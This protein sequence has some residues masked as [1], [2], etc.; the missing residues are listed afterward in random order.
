M[1]KFPKPKDLEK[2]QKKKNQYSSLKRTAI[3]PKK[4]RSKGEKIF[5]AGDHFCMKCFADRGVKN[6][7]LI[8]HGHYTGIRQN[9]FGKGRGIKVSDILKCPLCKKC[10]KYFD[11][12]KEWKSIKKSEEFLFLIGLFLKMVFEDGRL[13]M[14]LYAEKEKER[15]KTIL[16][17]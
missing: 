10:H 11:E 1:L 3:K 12:P 17:I 5:I 13:Y 6:Y 7:N 2:K 9:W 4:T 16:G 14:T 15:R 8:E